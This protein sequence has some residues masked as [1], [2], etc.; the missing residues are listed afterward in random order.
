MER[1]NRIIAN[2]PRRPYYPGML[3][4]LQIMLGRNASDCKRLAAEN[5]QAHRECVRAN[6]GFGRKYR[7]TLWLDRAA[8]YRR[9]AMELS[10]HENV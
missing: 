9:K 2:N 10:H 7:G 4:A 3:G 1:L 6:A 8:L 5:V